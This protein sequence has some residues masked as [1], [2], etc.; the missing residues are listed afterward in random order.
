MMKT[1]QP[2]QSDT[3]NLEDLHRTLADA[4]EIMAAF[5]SMPRS[6][7]KPLH[8]VVE[9]ADQNVQELAEW[10]AMMKE[11]SSSLGCKTRVH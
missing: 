7:E 9:A 8:S 6:D 3:P 2:M 1:E 5:L 4:S 11:L 10:R